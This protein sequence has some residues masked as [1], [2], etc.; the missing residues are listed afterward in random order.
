MAE[1]LGSLA[2]N[3]KV[4]GSIPGRA[5]LRCGLGQGTLPYLPQGECPCT[6]CK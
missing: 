1:W 2:V 6:Y 5:K 3:Q 4:V